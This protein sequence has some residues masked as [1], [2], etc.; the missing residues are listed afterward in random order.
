MVPV[1]ASVKELLSGLFDSIPGVYV[2]CVIE[3]LQDPVIPPFLLQDD[4]T[5]PVLR[6][7]VSHDI[8]IIH[9]ALGDIQRPALQFRL[10]PVCDPYVHIRERLLYRPVHDP[11]NG[12]HER[13][14]FEAFDRRVPFVQLSSRFMV[15]RGM[16][17]LT[18]CD[19]VPHPVGPSL[20][21]VYDV[22]DMKDRTITD[23]LFAALAGVIITG[24]DCLP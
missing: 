16:A 13:C 9:M 19:Q 24:K 22:V 20:A 10:C 17:F 8:S 11:P 21:P 18:D 3:L 1:R 5:D 6:M 15:L 4:R 14:P 23:R 2:F 12:S 7:E